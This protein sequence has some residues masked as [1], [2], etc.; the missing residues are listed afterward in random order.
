MEFSEQER[1]KIRQ[2]EVLRLQVRK[3]MRRRQRPRLILLAAL[4]TVVLT[5]L[6]LGSPYTHW[7]TR[8]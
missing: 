6:A 4:W 8:K 1:E 5:A 7:L 3:D 2:E